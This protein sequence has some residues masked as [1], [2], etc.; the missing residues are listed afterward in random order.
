[1]GARWRL[2]IV[3]GLFVAWVSWLGWQ[4]WR[5]SRF[6]VVS[7]AQLLETQ[8]VIVADLQANDEGRFLPQCSVVEVVWPKDGKSVKT[9][10]K[11]TI[12][13]L[14]GCSG[15]AGPGRYLLLLESLDPA[16]LAGFPRSPL[17]DPQKRPQVY[18]DG[19]DVRAQVREYY[20]TR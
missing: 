20:G 5:H 3:W 9:D 7:R 13:N 14:P 10:S 12:S 8:M 19:P 18:P 2:I 6:P 11:L 1:M 16:K 15:F 17:L 4:S